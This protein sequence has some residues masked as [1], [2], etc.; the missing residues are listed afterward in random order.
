MTARNETNPHAFIARPPVEARCR[1]VWWAP[2]PHWHACLASIVRAAEAFSL[3][4]RQ[5]CSVLKEIPYLV[6]KKTEVL[7]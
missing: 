5:A 3:S 6:A 1:S 7:D 4:A 2:V